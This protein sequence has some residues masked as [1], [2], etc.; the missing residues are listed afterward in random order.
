MES[1]EKTSFPAGAICRYTFTKNGA[2]YSLK[3]RISDDAAIKEEGIQESA[4]DVIARQKKARRN[5]ANAAKNFREIPDLGDEAFWGGTD[6]WLLKGE[7][8]FIISVNTPL[9]GSFQN[10]EAMNKA[11]SDQDLDLSLKV[12]ETVLSRLQ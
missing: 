11:R 8:L 1:P 9:A 2:S 7:T 10:M 3:L 5:S 12:A 6:L 4:A